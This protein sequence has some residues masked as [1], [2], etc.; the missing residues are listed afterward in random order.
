MASPQWHCLGA[1]ASLCPLGGLSPFNGVESGASGSMLPAGKV[2]TRYNRVAFFLEGGCDQA[3]RGTVATGH[4]VHPIPAAFLCLEGGRPATHLPDYFSLKVA[5]KAGPRRASRSMR[6]R[7]SPTLGCPK[8]VWLSLPGR[9]AARPYALAGPMRDRDH[10]GIM[11][12]GADPRAAASGPRYR[13]AA[14][15]FLFEIV[16]GFI[17]WSRSARPL[18]WRDCQARWNVWA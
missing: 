10:A 15:L 12:P 7:I 5:P 17:R 18:A 6:L 8:W 9:G 13:R 16:S 1:N 2:A 4:H 14:A 3:R 11:W